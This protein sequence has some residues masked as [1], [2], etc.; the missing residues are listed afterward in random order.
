MQMFFENHCSS[1]DPLLTDNDNKL[2]RYTTILTFETS[3]KTKSSDGSC[4]QTHA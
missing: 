4:K 2:V 3:L 1:T